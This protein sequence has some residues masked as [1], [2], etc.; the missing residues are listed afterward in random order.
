MIRSLKFDACMHVL[1]GNYVGVESRSACGGGGT[2][3]LTVI[4]VRLSL[5]DYEAKALLYPT[6]NEPTS[7]EHCKPAKLS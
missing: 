7:E 2:V 3:A 5:Q 1:G 4:F 6:S